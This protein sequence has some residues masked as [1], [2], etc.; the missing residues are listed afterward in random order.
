MLDTDAIIAPK[1][2]RGNAEGRLDRLGYKPDVEANDGKDS[3][4]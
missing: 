2:G 3:L 1:L 4:P